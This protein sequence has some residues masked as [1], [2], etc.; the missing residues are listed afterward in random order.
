MSFMRTWWL[1]Q[2]ASWALVFKRRDIAHEYFAKI[3]A[4]TPAD[5][6]T[7]SRVAFLY[8]ESGDRPRAVRE[9]ERV[10][11]VNPSDANS[12]FNLG[13]LRQEL[14]E[15]RAAIDAFDHALKI[16]EGHDRAA[17][18]KGLSLMALNQFDEAIAPLK[19]NVQL[20]PMSPYG[21]MALA[22]TY[23]KLGD[24]DRCEKR[25]RKLKA[26]DPKNAAVLEDE[27]GIKV[28]IERWWK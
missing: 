20:Q 18:G 3:L 15:H 26:F 1:T 21:H 10:V 24:V 16:N 8:S 14:L 27:T 5:A 9:F 6:V 25:M 22:R 7:L 12:W 19:K 23:F 13:F 11:S 4:H 2:I 17:Y 28:G